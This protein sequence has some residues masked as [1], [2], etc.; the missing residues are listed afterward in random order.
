MIIGTAKVLSPGTV[1]TF[2]ILSTQC[3]GP[4][5]FRGYVVGP[6]TYVQW[7]Q[8]AKDEGL[9]VYEE[10]IKLKVIMR[11]KPTHFYEVTTD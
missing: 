6:A 10:V 4:V 8:Q 2:S 9:N 7:Q 3:G 11:G 5:K 1:M